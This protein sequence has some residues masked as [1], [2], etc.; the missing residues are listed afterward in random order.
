MKC[1][2]NISCLFQFLLV[3]VEVAGVFKCYTYVLSVFESVFV[4]LETRLHVYSRKH[5]K[6]ILNSCDICF[7]DKVKFYLFFILIDDTN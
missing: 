3:L 5:T 7:L 4:H 6:M 1:G 2:D